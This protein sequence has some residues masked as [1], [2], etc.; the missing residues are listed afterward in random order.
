MVIAIS[1]ALAARVEPREPRARA[2]RRRH[3][4]GRVGADGHVLQRQSV[5]RDELATHGLAQRHVARA[6]QQH[7]GSRRDSGLPNGP[8]L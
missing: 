8:R 7:A 4:P 6:L 3:R 2:H 5:A 1:A